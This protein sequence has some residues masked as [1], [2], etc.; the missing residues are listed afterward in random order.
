MRL[1]I[2]R[3]H[4]GRVAAGLTVGNKRTADSAG[5]WSFDARRSLVDEGS[6]QFNGELSALS[7]KWSVTNDG[8]QEH[9]S[10]RRR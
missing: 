2:V 8:A 7:L 10:A 6:V 5:R 3:R 4:A 1:V 9:G